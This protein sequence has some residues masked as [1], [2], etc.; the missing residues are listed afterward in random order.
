[1]ISPEDDEDVTAVIASSAAVDF[2]LKR[3]LRWLK[4]L[5][6]DAC[7][8]GAA[9]ITE[10]EEQVNA[11]ILVNICVYVSGKMNL[12]AMCVCGSFSV[13]FKGGLSANSF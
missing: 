1:M 7:P 3:G 12:L 9:L 11:C 8:M 6:Q 10:G 4:L 2:G 5:V 13:A